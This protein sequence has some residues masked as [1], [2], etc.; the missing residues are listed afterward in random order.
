MKLEKD[1]DFILDEKSGYIVLTS[2]FLLKRGECC[3]NF[4]LNCPYIP[5]G[6][7]GNTKTKENT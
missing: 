5:I 6:I 7:K 2:H 1:I 3:G 4:C